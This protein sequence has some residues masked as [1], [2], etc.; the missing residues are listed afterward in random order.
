MGLRCWIR[1][2]LWRYGG[3]HSASGHDWDY[4]GVCRTCGKGEIVVTPT[5]SRSTIAL[6][7]RGRTLH[8]GRLRENLR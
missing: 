1:K 6:R 4:A 5:R 2:H 7:K 3:L 8:R